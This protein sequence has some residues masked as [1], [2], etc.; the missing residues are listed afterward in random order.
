MDELIDLL[1]AAWPEPPMTEEKRA[2]Y[3]SA[4][5][6]LGPERAKQEVTR[7]IG[8]D[9][10]TRPSPNVFIALAHAARSVPNVAIHDEPSDKPQIQG[11]N[12]DNWSQ[13]EDLL[14]GAWPGEAWDEKRRRI[15]ISTLASFEVA[16]VEEAVLSLARENREHTPSPGVIAN[17]VPT[18]PEPQ[19]TRDAVAA[20]PMTHGERAD[21]FRFWN[22]ASVISA[23]ILVLALALVGGVLLLNS[24][25]G[26]AG[27]SNS[28]SSGSS[29]QFTT[30]SAVATY[31]D[32]NLTGKDGG[33]IQANCPD[34]R[35]VS[36]MSRSL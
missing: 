29:A 27:S 24:R 13:I 9:R 36:R 23:A 17:R 3:R 8:E 12:P 30:G 14:H 10:S 33:S 7:L 26:S 31:L 16:E 22:K 2:E 15:Y 6:A 18:R 1:E 28:P 5:E 34:Q 35:L 32:Q 11:I 20:S 4:L 21:D 25:A 19:S